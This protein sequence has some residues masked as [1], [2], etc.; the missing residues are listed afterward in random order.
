[1]TGPTSSEGTPGLTLHFSV[2]VWVEPR[3]IS[4]APKLLRALVRDALTGRMVHVKSPAEIGEFIQ[5]ELRRID[6]GPHVWEGEHAG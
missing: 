2:D 4:G 6:A 1:M 3:T 5:A